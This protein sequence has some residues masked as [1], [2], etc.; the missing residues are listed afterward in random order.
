MEI[1]HLLDA[2]QQRSRGGE[3]KNL[4]KG[5]EESKCDSPHYRNGNEGEGWRITRGLRKWSLVLAMRVGSGSQPS[6]GERIPA[7]IQRITRPK[8]CSLDLKAAKSKLQMFILCR[9]V[10][11]SILF[12]LHAPL[13]TC[14]LF[15]FRTASPFS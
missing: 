1:P 13:I 10:F 8:G 6:F 12:S 11:S 4:C 9:H 7:S 15:W 5:G 3:K 14:H 2:S